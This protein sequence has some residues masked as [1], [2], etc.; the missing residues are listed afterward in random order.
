MR[1]LREH[2]NLKRN[3]CAICMSYIRN[4]PATDSK[5]RS[6][7]YCRASLREILYNQVGITRGISIIRLPFA[8]YSSLESFGK[9]Y[10][11]D[12][13]HCAGSNIKQRKITSKAIFGQYAE[14]DS[15]DIK[16]TELS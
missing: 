15:E 9:N 8:N 11:H 1:S 16:P 3:D 5:V 7:N 4:L 13:H 14:N 6:T 12:V 2:L 10:L